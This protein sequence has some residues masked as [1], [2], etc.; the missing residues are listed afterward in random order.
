MD[1]KPDRRKLIS[2]IAYDLSKIRGKRREAA[3]P[4]CDWITAVRLIE[5]FEKADS[6]SWF[7]RFRD[8]DFQKY[9]EIYERHKAD[10]D[11][12]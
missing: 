1:T 2:D 11:R 6:G 9:A 8:E 5:H 10:S 7:W 4:T 3:D 12:G